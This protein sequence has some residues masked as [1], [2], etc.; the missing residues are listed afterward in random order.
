MTIDVANEE[1]LTL[2]QLAKRLPRRRKGRPIHPSTIHRWRYPGIREVRLECV[3]V[4]GVWYTS[5]AAFQRFCERLSQSNKPASPPPTR[6]EIIRPPTPD[7]AAIE[8][9]LEERGA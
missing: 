8:R 9:E 7:Q 4:G 1:L 2:A 5:P 3:R 6:S